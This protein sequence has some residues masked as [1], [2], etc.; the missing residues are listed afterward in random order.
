MKRVM[1]LTALGFL[2]LATVVA[3]CSGDEPVRGEEALPGPSDTETGSGPPLDAPSLCTWATSVDAIVFGTVTR[4]E[5][6]ERPLVGVDG[7]PWVQECSDG[8]INDAL[9]IDLDVDDVIQGEVE[10]QTVTLHVGSRQTMFPDDMPVENGLLGFAM[11]QV[12]E[13]ALPPGWDTDQST[14]TVS[15][16]HFFSIDDDDEILFQEVG[17]GSEPPPE[18]VEGKTIAALEVATGE[19]EPTDETEERRAR[20]EYAWDVDEESEFSLIPEEYIAA[21]C[22]GTDQEAPEC[23]EDYDCGSEQSCVDEQ[24]VDD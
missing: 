14:W 1:T 17:T 5:R 12:P 20:A 9:E 4:V 19:C 23:I 11:H 7:D 22:T 3:G 16:E 15:K 8:A 21:V 10:E 2:L 6:V 18:N 24:C 13:S